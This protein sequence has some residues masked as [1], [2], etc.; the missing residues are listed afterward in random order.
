MYRIDATRAST[1]TDFFY[2][3]TES[4][5]YYFNPIPVCEETIIETFPVKMRLILD[6]WKDY[7]EY[8]KRIITVAWNYRKENKKIIK[9]NN[10]AVNIIVQLCRYRFCQFRRKVFKGKIIRTH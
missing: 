5:N 10:K 9:L 1:P 2:D 8:L 3:G 7:G 4:T 6:L